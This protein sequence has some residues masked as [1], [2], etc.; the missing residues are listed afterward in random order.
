[1]YPLV[2]ASHPQDP[3]QFAVGLTDGS[4]KVIEPT[5]SEGKWGVTPPADSGRNPS[6]I[7]HQQPCRGAASKITSPVYLGRDSHPFHDPV[8]FSCFRT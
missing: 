4:V 8:Y 7:I 1:M 5:E 6:S 2:V 3:N